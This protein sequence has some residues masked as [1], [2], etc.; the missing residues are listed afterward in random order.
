MHLR[1]TLLCSLTLFFGLLR[2]Q[3]TLHVYADDCTQP[4]TLFRFDGSTFKPI[5][6]LSG[7]DGHYTVTVED[8]TPRFYYVGT[9][10][11]AALLLI[12]GAEKEITL[13]GQCASLRTAQIE[14]SPINQAYNDLKAS[15]NQLHVRS[16]RAVTS[17]QRAAGKPE[18]Q[19]SALQ[20]MTEVDSLRLLLL[21]SLEKTNPFLARIASLNTYLSYFQNGRETY[22]GNEVGYFADTY[23]KFVD[24]KDA[25]YNDLPWVFES[26][27]NYTQALAG[28]NLPDEEL[29]RILRREVAKWPEGHSAR[30]YA[31]SGALTALRQK[32]HAGFLPLAE[33]YVKA[34]AQKDPEAVAS[35]QETM[36][37][38]QS[39]LVGGEAPDF[40]SVTPEG[41]D[42][43]LSDLR[44]KVVL[45][46][47]WA[48]WCGPCRRENPNVVRLYNKYKGRG[49]EILGVSLDKEREKWLAA[50]EQDGLTW[51]H[52]SDLKGWSNEVADQYSVRSIPH[53]ILLD[54]EGRILARGLRGPAL[55]EKLAEL[56]PE[57]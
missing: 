1:F 36:K 3:S 39:F 53:T 42:L 8:K 17:Y 33:E 37:G 7:A 48:S 30:Q 9:D 43:K 16:Q 14:G 45:I 44:G 24:H 12:L 35:L 31:H 15:F 46:D 38:M 25:G 23:F 49:F 6:S 56:F 41:Q 50:I 57:N 2:A 51:K 4:P 55:E 28:T 26:F 32:N 40:A 27:K 22:P 19:A 52:V 21:D 13:R 10:P 5:K 18:A 11:N 34:Y 20:T 54:A 29:L 47:F